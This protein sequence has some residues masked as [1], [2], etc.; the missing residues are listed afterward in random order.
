MAHD[1]PWLREECG[2]VLVEAVKCLPR[3]ASRK[4]ECEQ[5]AKEVIDR[6]TTFKLVSTPEGVAIWLTVHSSYPEVLPEGIWHDK[7][8]LSKK[9]RHRLAKILKGNFTGESENGSD[10]ATKSGT[11]NP[12][13]SFTWDVVF[14]E[15]MTRDGLIPTE[16]KPEFPRFWMDTVD[17]KFLALFIRSR[18]T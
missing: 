7:D 18:L 12:N 17:S 4:A 2:M 11:T 1:V 16:D 10:E 15:L 6:L 8:P 9:E 5:C 13:P 3:T 14:G